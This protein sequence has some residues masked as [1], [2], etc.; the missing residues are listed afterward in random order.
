MKAS[1]TRFEFRNTTT[2][3]EDYVAGGGKKKLGIQ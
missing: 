3:A 1:K 2:K